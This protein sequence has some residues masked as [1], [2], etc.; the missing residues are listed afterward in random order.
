MVVMKKILMFL[1]VIFL[2][3]T[4]GGCRDINSA[5][6]KDSFQSNISR[7]KH[8]ILLVTKYA[9]YSDH[10]GSIVEARF[11]D[12][13]GNYYKLPSNLA[14][15]SQ[16][17]SNGKWY[18]EAMKIKENSEPTKKVDDMHLNTM[19]EFIN[20]LDSY[21]SCSIKEYNYTI[22]DNGTRSLYA[23]FNSP[24]G[25]VENKL[26]CTYGQSTKCVD[27]DEVRE[28]VN[29]MIDNG[30]FIIGDKDFRY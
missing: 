17:T 7:P 20:S 12:S 27:C 10:K 13:D 16:L 2:L 4:L 30:Y 1:S 22:Y 28:F 3:C 21:V 19:Y 8:E 24:N 5:Y 18:E 25:T 11:I 9:S 15:I 23:C 29:W 14:D 6:T 26:L